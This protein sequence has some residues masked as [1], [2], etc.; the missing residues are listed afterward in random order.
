MIILKH[1]TS[2]FKN[3]QLNHV[4]A[5]KWFNDYKSAT[6]K[7]TVLINIENGKKQHIAHELIKEYENK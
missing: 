5:Q 2:F 3:I 1:F 4:L 6:N 7:Q